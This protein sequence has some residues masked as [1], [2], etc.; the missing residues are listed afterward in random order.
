MSPTVPLAPLAMVIED[1]EKLSLIYSAAL[2]QAG[3]TVRA[4]R[5]GDL[6]LEE[7]KI[8]RPRLIVLD[9]QLPAVPGITILHAIRSDPILAEI[10]VIVATSDYIMA[11]TLE[12]QGDLVLI[13]PVSFTQLR[14]LARRMLNQI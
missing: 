3:C 4:V 11:Q 8:Y 9:L 5:R 13:K 10:R 14:D 7:L 2:R 1:D 12:E 6:A